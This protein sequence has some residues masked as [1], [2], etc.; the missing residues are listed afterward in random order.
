MLETVDY[1]SFAETCVEELKVLQVMRS[2]KMQTHT[3]PA[4]EQAAPILILCTFNL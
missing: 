3:L 4:A 1:N 2:Q